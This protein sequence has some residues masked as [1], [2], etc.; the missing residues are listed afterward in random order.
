MAT[1]SRRK[2]N[3][4]VGLPED[5][6]YLTSCY[7]RRC[8]QNKSATEFYDA[9][10]KLLDG[11]GK[12]SV[13]RS[14]ID[15]FFQGF[16]VKENDL[17][18]AVYQ[19]CKIINVRYDASAI[20]AT[21]KHIDTN[22]ARNRKTNYIF[23]AYLSKL[24]ISNFGQIDIENVDFTFSE[25]V[26]YVSENAIPLEEVLDDEEDIEY[27]RSVWGENLELEDYRFLEN[28]YSKWTRTT[29]VD[30]YGV[31]ILLREICHKENEIR[32][33]RKEN[34]SVDTLLKALQEI[35]KNSALTPALQNAAS[36]GRSA[37]A[38]GVWIKDIENLT[39]A[40]WYEEE[41]RD[42]YKDIE[43][44][45]EYNEIFIKRS[46]KNFLTGSRDFNIEEILGSGEETDDF[47]EG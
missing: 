35:M 2:K 26:R 44:I 3:V 9:T 30:N 17:N 6:K 39:P 41:Y 34:K 40:E 29:E 36:S 14:C 31:E 8:M 1:R 46:I 45:E 7:C 32:K 23:G 18:D 43:G 42:K 21:Q 5:T 13:C 11:N 28:A 25:P 22:A 33:A 10:D 27:L 15:Y 47:D 16:Y 20:E 38:F 24:K 37:D 4:N 19:T 12:M